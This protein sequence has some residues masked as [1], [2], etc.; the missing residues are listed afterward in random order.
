MSM[1]PMLVSM[2]MMVMM[3]MSIRSHYSKHLN[4]HEMYFKCGDYFGKYKMADMSI[5]P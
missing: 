4:A 1:L 3:R 2:G 5:R